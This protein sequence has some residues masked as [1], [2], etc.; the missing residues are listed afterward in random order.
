MIPD[1]LLRGFNR[2]EFETELKVWAKQLSP[3]YPESTFVTTNFEYT[4]WAKSNDLEE[5]RQSFVRVGHIYDVSYVNVRLKR[6]FLCFYSS[7]ATR[8][9]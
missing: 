7:K 3:E 4:N 8:Q 9:L 6:S 5:N 1:L 2:S